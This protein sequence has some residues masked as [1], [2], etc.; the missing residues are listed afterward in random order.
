MGRNSSI[1]KP[2]IDE[3]IE[4]FCRS[5][6]ELLTNIHERCNNPEKKS[7]RGRKKKKVQVEAED[8]DKELV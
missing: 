7:K 3:K 5:S 8:W 2:S 6:T 1:K 4:S